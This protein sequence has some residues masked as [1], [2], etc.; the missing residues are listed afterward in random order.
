[1]MSA[2]ASLTTGDSLY[3]DG[4]YECAIDH[5]TSAICLSDERHVD[6]P[7]NADK[8]KTDRLTLRFLSLS[9]RSSAHYFLSQY[10]ASFSDAREAISLIDINR[11]DFERKNAPSG[12]LRYEQVAAC[13][14]RAA[15]CAMALKEGEWTNE[16]RGHWENAMTLAAMVENGEALV[17]R[18][19]LCIETLDVN[20]DSVEE[21]A[22]A[23]TVESAAKTEAS[24]PVSKTIT[25]EA[26]PLPTSK[27]AT[28]APS[29]SSSAQT[30]KY[31]YYQDDSWMKIQIM[32][33]NLSSESCTVSIEPTSINVTVTKSR[34]T[35]TVIHGDLYE[36]VV[37]DRCRT[38][39]KDEK[40]LIKLKKVKSGD[41]YALLDDK[42][43]KK[44]APV[45]EEAT[46]STASEEKTAE[47]ESIDESTNAKKTMPRPYASTKDWDAINRSLT[48]AE[49][50]ENP[51]GDEALNKLFKQIYAN[52]SEDTRRAMV[53]SMQTSGGTVLSTNW[54]EVSKADYE[55]ERVAPKGMEWK[56]YE[57]DKLRMKEDD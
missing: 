55:K 54:D 22:K 23:K 11:H 31:Q 51:E 52:A 26:A 7:D 33:P 43:K 40:V 15:R 13:H 32:E 10:K 50:A 1:M 45:E 5:Y 8:P 3:V 6:D 57:G 9:H 46:A 27:T 53:K 30:P 56:N 17:E 25:T 4:L 42:N 47:S 38:I 19:Q 36:S 18:Y 49:E 29:K 2:H 39:F 37:V 34:T 14:D 16:A 35:Y 24:S 28:A 48:Q 12:K 21:K 41:W 44:K 20:T